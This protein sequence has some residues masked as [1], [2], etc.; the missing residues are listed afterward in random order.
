M[1]ESPTARDVIEQTIADASTGSIV[2]DA[3]ADAVISAI[4]TLGLKRLAVLLRDAG[5][6]VRV[7]ATGSFKVVPKGA[8][9]VAA[10]EPA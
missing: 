3:E 10:K 5:Y 1:A 2:H 6:D 4:G 7:A 9:V 8:L